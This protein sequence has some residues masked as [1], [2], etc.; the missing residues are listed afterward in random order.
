MELQIRNKK[1]FYIDKNCHSPGQQGCER[2]RMIGKKVWWQSR[3]KRKKKDVV[4]NCHSNNNSLNTRHRFC[5]GFACA[6]GKQSPFVH[7]HV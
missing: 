3:T 4:E 1:L 2:V 5:A 6:L 7:F